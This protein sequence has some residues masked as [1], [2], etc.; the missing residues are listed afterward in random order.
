[1]GDDG[2]CNRK[3]PIFLSIQRSNA[4]AT[5]KLS[6]CVSFPSSGFRLQRH[7]PLSDPIYPEVCGGLLT[8]REVGP[9]TFQGLEPLTPPRC[10]RIP[11]SAWLG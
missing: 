1:M 6:A 10:T 8:K 11:L 9:F 4:E 3:A 5:A 2:A 7:C